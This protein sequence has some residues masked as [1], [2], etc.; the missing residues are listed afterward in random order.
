MQG[1]NRYYPLDGD[2]RK[3]KQNKRKGPEVVRFELPF[4]IYCDSCDGRFAQGTRYNAEKTKNGSYY[5]TTVW[6]FRMKCSNCPGFFAIQTDP[7]NTKYVVVEGARQPS[8]ELRPS[9]DEGEKEVKDPENPFSKLEQE[10]EREQKLESDKAELK[11]IYNTNFRQWEDTLGSSQNL[12]KHFRAEKR[13]I[14]EK[15]KEQ[16]EVKD[17]HSLSIPLVDHT[18]EDQSEAKKVRFTDSTVT[19]AERELRRKKVESIFD[20]SKGENN[21]HSI[22]RDLVESDR[23]VFGQGIDYKRRKKNKNPPSPGLDS[24]VDYSSSD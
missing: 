10:K 7:K 16:R 22:V 1:Y 20:G 11:E 21:N 15:E 24:L 17:R 6:K 4:D 23:D 2:E 8:A 19:A 12:R 5:S 14:E 13:E 18:P 9:R 3:K